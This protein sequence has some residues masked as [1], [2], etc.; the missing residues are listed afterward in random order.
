[1][2]DRYH[3][4]FLWSLMLLGFG[5]SSVV[6][7]IVM[8]LSADNMEAMKLSMESNP[9]PWMWMNNGVQL[10]AFFLPAAL[11]YRLAR[12]KESLP[13]FPTMTSL[14]I[15]L[16]AVPAFGFM[17]VLGE[18]NH[19]IVGWMPG[20]YDE[21]LASEQQI[22]SITESMLSSHASH[23]TVVIITIAL[24]PALFEEFFFRGVLQRL[25]MKTK[26][27][28]TAIWMS[29]AAFSLIHF[30][31]L[32]FIPRLVM[33]AMLGYITWLTGNWWYS[34]GVHFLNNLAGVVL[35]IS[36]GSMELQEE[37][38]GW[39]LIY[40]VVAAVFLCLWAFLMRK[41]YFRYFHSEVSK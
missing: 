39:T 29:A 5:L 7:P 21:V 18:L 32:G 3:V 15:A 23:L 9:L 11:M 35:F 13:C 2:S 20:L 40:P 12:R 41:N 38:V 30:Q 37:G 16:L 10:F 31:F 34:A 27:A 36:F 17:D 22:E 24:V 14:T 28:H 26:G 8:G 25:F 6:L 1:M 4:L 33:G 19:I